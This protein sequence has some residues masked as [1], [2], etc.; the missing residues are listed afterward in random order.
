MDLESMDLGYTVTD[1]S[2]Q[3]QPVEGEKSRSGSDECEYKQQPRPEIFEPPEVAK[4]AS[5]EPI[6]AQPQPATCFWLLA[7]EHQI[8]VLSLAVSSQLPVLAFL[9]LPPNEFQ[10]RAALHVASTHKAERRTEKI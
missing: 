3:E 7:D 8:V 5:P 10:Q 6:Q 9:N 1:F 2:K 4:P